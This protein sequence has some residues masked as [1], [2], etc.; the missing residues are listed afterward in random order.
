MPNTAPALSAPALW[1][2]RSDVNE[3][4]ATDPI[5]Q[6]TTRPLRFH[7]SS[8]VWASSAIND[9]HLPRVRVATWLTPRERGQVD[10]AGDGY[11]TTIHAP[12]FA[13]ARRLVEAGLVDAAVLSAEL[14]RPELLDDV[15]QLV[16]DSP[17]SLVTGLV[18]E[19]NTP[20]ALVGVFLLGSAGVATVIDARKHEGW[21]HLRNTFA[22]LPRADAFMRSALTTVLNDV[23]PEADVKSDGISPGHE[24]TDLCKSGALV[25]FLRTVF[26]SGIGTVRA[27]ARS[28]GTRPSTITC[29]FFRAC[30]PSPKRYLVGARLVHLAHLAESPAMSLASIS[31]LLDA[32]SPQ[33]LARSV[34]IATGLTPT[35]FRQRYS[36]RAMLERFRSELIFPYVDVLRCFD[37]IARSPR[38][39]HVT[40]GSPR[41]PHRVAESALVPA[42]ND[43]P[44]SRDG[45][46]QRE[47]APILPEAL[48]RST[49]SS[50][51]SRRRGRRLHTLRLVREA[52]FA[53]SDD[54]FWPGLPIRN[55]REVF[56]LMEPYAAREVVEAFWILPLTTQHRLVGRAPMIISRG[57]LNSSLVHPREVFS[58]AIV[59]M[60]AAIIL[61]HNHP[62][63]DPTPSVED[64]TITEQLVAA[65]R[66]LDIPVHDHVVMGR[67]SF[68]SFAEAGL[69]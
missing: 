37:P 13:I 67:G 22:V 1:R 65:G 57:I 69:I 17:C 45:A 16:Q 49:A 48:G 33:S 6:G 43:P 41:S 27:L 34:R 44:G 64:R 28:L 50:A 42:P 58:A 9:L 61:V 36:G 25:S 7:E 11:F 2:P 60:C 32:S 19:A 5:P 54:S 21:S 10:D 3:G 52:S 14:M 38:C 39:E 20:T 46:S 12:T 29:R 26:I 51:A 47:V 62:S 18:T 15:R 63:G 40:A 35:A 24:S 68:L 8:H 30:L 55:P 4:T 56:Q 23:I 53:V 59:A 31:N 66:L